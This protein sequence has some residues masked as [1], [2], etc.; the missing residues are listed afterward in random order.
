MGVGTY[1]C[2]LR[3]FRDVLLQ[4]VSQKLTHYLVVGPTRWLL[5][6]GGLIGVH[7]LLVEGVKLVL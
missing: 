3:A 5:A 4:P 2:I 6:R 7:M 1:A